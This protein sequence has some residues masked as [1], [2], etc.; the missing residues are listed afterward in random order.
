MRVHWVVYYGFM[1][2]FD[3]YYFDFIVSILFQFIISMV[4][5]LVQINDNNRDMF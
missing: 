1:V 3:P 5:D 4:L 2:R